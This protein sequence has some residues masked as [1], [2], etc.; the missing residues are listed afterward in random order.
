MERDGGVDPKSFNCPECRQ[1]HFLSSDRNSNSASQ[2]N[3]SDIVLEIQ[4]DTKLENSASD[5]ANSTATTAPIRPSEK[6]AISF[7]SEKEKQGDGSI[8]HGNHL[9]RSTLQ[10]HSNGNKSS[11]FFATTLHG[12]ETKSV[13]SDSVDDN[14]IPTTAFVYIGKKI[15]EKEGGYDF[16]SDAG[17]EDYS[18]SFSVVDSPLSTP[19]SRTA[20]S[21]FQ[22]V[23]LTIQQQAKAKPSTFPPQS[24]SKSK[25]SRATSS[26][27]TTTTTAVGD[28]KNDNS[29]NVISS[30]STA[31]LSD[32]LRETVIEED[33][34]GFVAVGSGS[35]FSDCGRPLRWK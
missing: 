34:D 23:P 27:A 6:D 10:S 17:S 3:N 4:P 12:A 26:A 24:K 32:G 19:S 30:S 21:G 33:G 16:L 11:N 20:P 31:A 15:S 22:I 13:L 1:D 5:T 2:P 25:S 9:D 14:D 18:H 8:S 35:G 29:V 28:S 7:A